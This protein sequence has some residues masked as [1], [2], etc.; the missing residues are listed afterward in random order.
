MSFS[1]IQNKQV[2]GSPEI[3]DS[4]SGRGFRYTFRDDYGTLEANRPS[5]GEDWGGGFVTAA[6]LRQLGRSDIGEMIVETI[7]PDVT[8]SVI[9]S[10][11]II[12]DEFPLLEIDNESV[13]KSLR[14]HPCFNWFDEEAWQAIDDWM[15]ETDSAQRK[16]FKY[17][18]RDREG[19]PV[20]SVKTLSA[21]AGSGQ[22]SQ[23][24]FAALTQKGITDYLDYAVIARKTSL[25]IG[26]TPPVVDLIG[27]KIS[28]DPFSGVP[29]GLEWICR[30]DRVTKQGRG[31]FWTRVQEWVGVL[32]V[33]VDRDD[34]FV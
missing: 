7:S 29:S 10:S 11:Q 3:S 18:E 33:A 14:S 1:A 8:T 12:N 15:N 19:A 27:Q 34:I 2:P 5:I 25:Y 31:F 6:I 21:S 4:S 17:F 24:V 13:Q 22:K 9:G 26:S 28:G 32:E 30:G 16:A 20:G 23:Q